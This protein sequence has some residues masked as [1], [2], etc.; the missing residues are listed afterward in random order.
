MVNFYLGGKRP[1]PPQAPHQYASAPPPL[2]RWTL[3]DTSLLSPSHSRLNSGAF[4]R[5][6]GAGRFTGIIVNNEG[7]FQARANQYCGQ[8]ATN[9]TL[10]TINNKV[11]NDFLYEWVIQMM[12]QPEPVWIGLHANAMGQWG[13]YNGEPVTYTNWDF[14]NYEPPQVGLGATLFDADPIHQM[15]NQVD[16]SPQWRVEAGRNEPHFFICEY[17]PGG[18]SAATIQPPTM[19]SATRGPA[20]RPATRRPANRPATRRPANRPAFYNLGNPFGGSR[21]YEVLRRPAAYRRNPYYGMMPWAQCAPVRANFV[22]VAHPYAHHSLCHQC[23]P[24]FSK[25][26]AIISAAF[27]QTRLT[28][29]WLTRDITSQREN[30]TKLQT[31]RDE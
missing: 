16:V 11:E 15:N 8:L 19:P 18:I 27:I 12:V 4:L 29:T 30:N 14:G 5:A 9:A 3:P 31:K 13:W 28:A 23:H 26:G 21:L 24:A 22:Y 10:V 20:N 7:M 25:E 17:R 2:P 6:P 1:P